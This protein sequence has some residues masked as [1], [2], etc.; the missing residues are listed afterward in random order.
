MDSSYIPVWLG[1][2]IEVLDDSKPLDLLARDNFRR[3][4]RVVSSLEDAPFT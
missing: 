1:R 2:P 4:A 3:V